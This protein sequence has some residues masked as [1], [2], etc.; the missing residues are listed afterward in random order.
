MIGLFACM[1]DKDVEGMLEQLE[2]VLEE[3]VITRTTSMRAMDPARLADLA[4]EYFGEHR[5]HFVPD[6]PDALDRAAELA[7][8]EGGVGGGVIA[9][10]SVFVAAEVRAL[11]GA[12]S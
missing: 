7:D 8:T 1:E 3:I 2:P 11:L 9:T 4:R 5:V 6:L 10:G 12:D